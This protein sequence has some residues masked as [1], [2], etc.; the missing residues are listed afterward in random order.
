MI[1]GM[2]NAGLQPCATGIV[3]IA[4]VAAQLQPPRDAA[5]PS[6]GTA[7]ISGVVLVDGDTKKPARRVR[8]TL[9]NLARTSPG[10]TTTTD[11]RGAFAFHNLAA[12]RYELQG[13]KN[14]YLRTSYGAARPDRTGTPIAVKDGEAVADL[15]MSIVRGGVITG[16]VRDMR[17]GPVPGVSVRVLR[18]AYD[19][20]TGERTLRTSSSGSTTTTDDRGEYRAYGLPPGGYLVL[21]PPPATGRGDEPS[22]RQLTSGDVQ[23][24]V[25][26]ARSGNASVP[27]GTAAAPPSSSGTRVT[28]A[29]IFHPGVT[30]IGAAA[31]IPLGLGEERGGVDITT[32]LVAT[33]TVTVSIGSG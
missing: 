17:G 22:I 33:A 31:V 15:K 12:G 9:T 24:A 29:P 4:W 21:V 28:Y 30:D 20:I 3:V 14:A 6:Q 1:A 23:R 5:R 32:Q 19:A 26:A 13:F 2:V 7:S 25:Q 11:D 27:G 10:Q 16:V 18:F 8:V